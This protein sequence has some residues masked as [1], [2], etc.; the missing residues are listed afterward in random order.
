MKFHAAIYGAAL[1]YYGKPP[2]YPRTFSLKTFTGREGRPITPPCRC[3]APTASRQG[4]AVWVQANE[5]APDA[6]I[7]KLGD[8]A[9]TAVSSLTTD[10]EYPPEPRRALDMGRDFASALVDLGLAEPGQPVED[11]GAGPHVTIPIPAIITAEHGGGKQTSDAV[12]RVVE[13]HMLPLFT[14]LAERH[15]LTGL[16]DLGAYDIGRIF[17]LPGTWRPGNSKPNEAEYLRCGYLRRWLPP[18]D[19]IPPVRR[20][21][22]RLADLIIQAA[23]ELQAE[24]AERA[25][26]HLPV[27]IS[28]GGRPGDDY[29]R[30]TGAR[31]VA[32]L[33]TCHGW[34]ITEDQHADKIVLSPP[35]S[36]RSRQ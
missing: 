9:I 34:Q 19:N 12:A 14:E 27:G 26:S 15:G 33:L 28:T 6:P 35:P 4:Y 1:A 2:G 7:K 5:C 25:A 29:N 21:C 13:R 24:A 17:S 18:Y 23:S 11:S 20:E 10:W 3:H 22:A 16:V 36:G 30:R 31:D 8:A 32:R